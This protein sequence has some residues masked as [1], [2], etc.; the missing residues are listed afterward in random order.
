[1]YEYYYSVLVVVGNKID[2]ISTSGYEI[3][4]SEIV[5]KEEAEAYAK[6]IN[7]PYYEVSAK[8]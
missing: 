3:P 5:R 1:M 6:S 8:N 7:A 2:L 4:E